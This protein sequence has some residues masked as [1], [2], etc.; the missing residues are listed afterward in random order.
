MQYSHLFIFTLGVLVGDWLNTHTTLIL[1]FILI[2]LRNKPLP[3]IFG[4][5]EPNAIMFNT[6]VEAWTFMSKINKREET[7]VK[8]VQA[9]DMVVAEPVPATV[10]NNI[11]TLNTTPTVQQVK[12]PII[13]PVTTPKI[14]PVKT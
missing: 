4:G 3:E 13:V 2:M 12:S 7:S 6:L 8:L 10:Q 14:K 1:I 5:N 9:K 11:N